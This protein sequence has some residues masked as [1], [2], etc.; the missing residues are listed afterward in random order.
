MKGVVAKVH[1]DTL[2]ESPD[3]YK[4]VEDVI[5]AQEGVVINVINHV[6]PII[7]IKG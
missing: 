1:K 6:K 7:N 2:D 4:N 5:K 3:A